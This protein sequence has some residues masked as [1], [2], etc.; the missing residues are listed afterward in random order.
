MSNTKFRDY[1]KADQSVDDLYKHNHAKQTVK[2]V[3]DCIKKHCAFNK[4]KM[5]IQEALEKSNEIID[6]S[7]PDLN[8]SQTIHAYQTAEGLRK[9]YPNLEWLPLVGLIH[10]LGKILCLSE[11]GKL[12]QWAVV[13]DTFPVGCA[14]SKDIIYYNHF[15]RNYDFFH[16]IYSSQYGIYKP[17]CGLDNVL[18]SFGHDEYLYRVLKHNK[19][20]IPDLGLRIIRYHSFYAFHKN[21]AYEYLMNDKD[22]ELR[23]WC[24]KFSSCDLYTKDNDNLPN[25]DELKGRYDKLIDKYCPG[26]LEW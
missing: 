11:Y 12:P 22:Y 13:G 15:M 25:I 4:G 2:F 9:Q 21:N 16:P 20:K 23:D 1:S 24:K 6:S 7:D 14:F 3:K 10:D 19:C 18:F 5:T 17:N 8:L 26:I